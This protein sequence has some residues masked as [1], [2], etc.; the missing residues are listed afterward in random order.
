MRA[1]GFAYVVKVEASFTLAEAELLRREARAHYDA[2]CREYA[3]AGP[4][5]VINGMV[6]AA[7]LDGSGTF[8]LT[9]HEVDVLQKCVEFNP[10]GEPAADW[11]DAARDLAHLRALVQAEARCLASDWS[12]STT[13]AMIQKG[14]G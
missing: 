5:G 6:N 10:S 14:R 8:H 13:A 1:A 12:C 2:L 11:L 4:R 7:N 9:E 3:E